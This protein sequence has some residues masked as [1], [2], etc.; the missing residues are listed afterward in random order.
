MISFQPST[1]LRRL[2]LA[3]A[4][5]SGVM[6]VA[7]LGVG[8]R[9]ADLSRLPQ[10]LLLYAGVILVPWAFFVAFLAIQRNPPL[11][12][13]RLVVIGNAVWTAVSL[14]LLVL[15]RVSPNA[16]G[17]GF[18]VAQALAVGALGALQLVAIQGCTASATAVRT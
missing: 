3:D 6:A 17:Y 12:M 5:A 14:I 2:L 8:G 16:L 11:G 4:I 10:S 18:I 7:L 1:F 15:D 9:L 13:L